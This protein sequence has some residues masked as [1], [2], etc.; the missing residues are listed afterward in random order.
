MPQVDYE[1]LNDERLGE[2][3]QEVQA[4]VEAARVLK[5]SRTFADP[6]A[7][8]EIT[9]WHLAEALQYRERINLQ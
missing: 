6:A 1:K 2:G 3:S 5:L 8:D 4:R 7:E 9:P